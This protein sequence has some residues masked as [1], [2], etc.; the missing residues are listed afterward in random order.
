LRFTTKGFELTDWQQ[1]AVNAWLTGVDGSPGRGT[2]EIVTGGGKTLIALACAAALSEREPDLK[3]AV[4]VPTQALARQWF[5]RIAVNTTIDRAQIGLLGAGGKS[6]LAHVR[7]LVAVLNTAAKALPGMA[8]DQQPLLLIVDEA[9]RAGAP[10]FSR[11]LSTPAKYRLGLSATPD[12]EEVDDDGE[13]LSFDEQVVGLRLGG[14]VA[15]FGLKEA[16]EAGWLP[17]Y[18]LFHHAVSLTPEERAR[19]D[20]VS[21]D[22]DEAG[23]TL[24]ALGG[25]HSRARMLS[26]RAGDLGQAAKRWVMLTSQRKDLLYRASERNRVASLLVAQR[27]AQ[28]DSE[29]RVIL[30]HERVAEAEQLFHTLTTA[31]PTASCVLENSRM[32]ESK[33]RDAL[34]RFASGAASVL[35]SVK[36]LVE[37]IDVP[38]ADTGVSVAATASVRQRIQA[39]GRVLRRSVSDAGIVKRSEMHLIYVDD[40]VDDL[41]Y[42]KTDWADL[43]GPEANRYLKWRAGADTPTPLSGPP[44]TPK[45]TEPDA[46]ARI[47]ASPEVALPT[48]WLGEFIGQEYSVGAGG[49]V[50][51]AFQTL[52]TNPQQVGDMVNSVR[53]DRGGRFR[54]TPQLRLVLVWRTDSEGNGEPWVAGRLSEPFEVEREVEAVTDPSQLD[55]TP[56]SEYRGPSDREGGTLHLTQKG[57]GQLEKRY[58][59]GRE[60]ALAEGPSTQAANA[61]LVVDAWRDLGMPTSRVF[62]NSLDHVWYESD[63]GR[64]FLAV[65]HEG[66]CW[67]SDERTEP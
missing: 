7:A 63:S 17:E 51:N 30:F 14:V 56:G 36:S 65:V 9:H 28:S 58:R 24:Q 40:T 60:F 2:I 41:I 12:R 10:S 33:R 27:F 31:L 46:W 11:V 16:R 37:G 52:I 20:R 44:R 38:A 64:R 4:V 50:H 5:E 43:T 19:Y 26:S 23:D 25:D 67:P 21:R 39:L 49:V 48:P 18:T 35:V 13:P 42:G 8:R 1:Q 45:P 53:G 6:D 62:V 66:F 32:P 29:S 15:R 59:G 54:V 34:A 47:E 55:L 22:V 3:I 57:G 61:R